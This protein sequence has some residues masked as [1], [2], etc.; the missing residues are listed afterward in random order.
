ML[1]LYGPEVRNNTNTVRA[2]AVGYDGSEW[3]YVSY[4]DIQPFEQL[5]YYAENR[6]ED[7]FPYILLKRYLRKLGIRAFEKD[8]YLP[9]SATLIQK[10][11]PVNPRTNEF[12][13]NNPTS[14]L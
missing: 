3:T 8:F 7:R 9:N 2:I 5:T 12:G 14:A 10:E 11:G 13:L 4:G 1:E 6:K